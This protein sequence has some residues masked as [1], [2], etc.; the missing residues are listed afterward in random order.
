MAA[1]VEATAA[2]AAAT[3]PSPSSPR[4]VEITD[5]GWRASMPVGSVVGAEYFTESDSD[6]DEDYVDP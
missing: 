6:C 4:D 2:V 1:A 5:V 3:G